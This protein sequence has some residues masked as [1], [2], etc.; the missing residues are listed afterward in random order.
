MSKISGQFRI[1][2]HLW[3]FRTTGN[4][5]NYTYTVLGTPP[6]TTS[7]SPWSTSGS[8]VDQPSACRQC[9]FVTQS[10]AQRLTMMTIVIRH[11][12]MLR[13]IRHK[14]TH[15]RPVRLVLDL[16]LYLRDGR[17][18]CSGSFDCAPSDRELNPRPPDR[19]S[20]ALTAAPPQL[21][22]SVIGMW[23][24]QP[25]SASVGCGFHVQNPSDSDADASH[26]QNYQLL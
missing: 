14:W 8:R 6:A 24:S 7:S 17:L 19:K 26:D 3:N 15:R 16:D 10:Y 13:A 21:R 11:H 22:V 23:R 2:G 9:H 1:S 20:D 12:T 4:P 5:E 25:I 18:S